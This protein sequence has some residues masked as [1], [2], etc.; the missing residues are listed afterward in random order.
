MTLRYDDFDL[1]RALSLAAEDD[2]GLVKVCGF[3]GPTS[4][5]V[6]GYA[7]EQAEHDPNCTVH[8]PFGIGIRRER[9]K[10]AM[11]SILRRALS[12]EGGRRTVQRLASD[13]V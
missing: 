7:L 3:L 2:G 10:A 5:I 1:K 8:M 4:K 9:S 6:S 11:S 12:A 13:R